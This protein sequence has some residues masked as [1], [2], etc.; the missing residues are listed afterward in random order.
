[1]CVT[2]SKS[3]SQAHVSRPSAGA[4]GVLRSVM[5]GYRARRTDL[6]SHSYSAA[7][8]QGDLGEVIELSGPWHLYMGSSRND[9]SFAE[10]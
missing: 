3:P 9:T 5:P 7:G 6:V 8:Q 1:M 2:G 4:E 10:L